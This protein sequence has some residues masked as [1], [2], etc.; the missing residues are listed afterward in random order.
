MSAGTVGQIVVGAI[1]V[2]A[3]V[4]PW[5][6]RL[7]AARRAQ[8]ELRVLLNREREARIKRLEERLRIADQMVSEDE[9]RAF[10][11]DASR[12]PDNAA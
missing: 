1:I 5:I 7:L 12:Q 3:L 4:S 9:A 6:G 11:L 2:S 10:H 8:V